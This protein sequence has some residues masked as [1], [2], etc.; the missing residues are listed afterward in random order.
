MKKN[1]N[2]H[3]EKKESGIFMKSFEIT[4]NSYKCKGGIVIQN[5]K[6]TITMLKS[7]KNI[8]KALF[9]FLDKILME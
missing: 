2:H 9:Y 4:S 8:R 1:F 5:I 3:E 7:Q 6:V